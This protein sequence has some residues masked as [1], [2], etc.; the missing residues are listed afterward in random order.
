[1]SAESAE[2]GWPV[3]CV[4]AGEVSPVG[5]LRRGT[6]WPGS[7]C[8]VTRVSRVTS[9]EDILD[10]LYY[11]A[12]DERDKGDKFERMMLQYLKTDVV[13]AQRFAKVYMW[14]DGPQRAGAKDN[15]VDLVAIE[16]ETGDAVAIQCKFFDPASTLYKQ[17]IDSFLSESGK[18]PFRG[19]IVVSTTDHWGPNAEAAIHDQ[20]IPVE[21]LRF[22]DLAESSID[23]SS[24]LRLMGETGRSMSEAT[25]HALPRAVGGEL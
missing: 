8:L 2:W 10:K 5:A 24:G 20:Q 25:R 19:R 23:W 12:T 3:R 9:V 21:R 6:L 16:R 11:S 14:M 13:Y 22:M 1:M 18:N 15:G 4:V 17:H 7:A